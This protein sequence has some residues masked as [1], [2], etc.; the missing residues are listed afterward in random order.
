MSTPVVSIE[1]H[2]SEP[3]PLRRRRWRTVIAIGC[4]VLATAVLWAVWFSSLFAIRGVEVVGA[5]GPPAQRVESIAGV[6]L[7]LPLAQ[8]DSA[9]VAAKVMELGWVE[10]VEVRRGWPNT[11]VLAVVPRTPVA[12]VADS[13]KV[14]DASGF[15]YE[16]AI[17]VSAPLVPIDAEGPALVAAVAVVNGLPSDLRERVASVSASTRDDVELTLQSGS[18]VRWGSAERGEFKAEVLQALLPRRARMYD[19]TAPELPTTFAERPRKAVS[20]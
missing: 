16:P 2:R 1:D 8:L 6:P 10:S 9:A 12:R 15:A 5:A 7:G 14:A 13:G 11:V 19:V 17:P 20:R 4:A 3:R 18:V